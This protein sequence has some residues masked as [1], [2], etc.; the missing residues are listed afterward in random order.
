[1]SA[2]R[3]NDH[4]FKMDRSFLIQFD[5]FEEAEK[6]KLASDDLSLDDRLRAIEFLRMQW[7]EMNGL[8]TKMDRT[9][10]EYR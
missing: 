1:M 2:E 9:Y 5:S 10:F 8:S 7:I 6:I 4:Q 3:T